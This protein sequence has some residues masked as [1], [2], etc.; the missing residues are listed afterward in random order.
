MDLVNVI[1]LAGNSVLEL[2]SFKVE[3]VAKAEQV[4][5][6]LVTAK[7]GGDDLEYYLEEGH[8]GEP[9]YTV[10]IHHSRVATTTDPRVLDILYIKDVVKEQ[11]DI[12][13]NFMTGNGG[14]LVYDSFGESATKLIT[15]ISDEGVS[16]TNYYEDVEGDTEFF[17]YSELSDALI[18]EIRVI[19]ERFLLD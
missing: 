8:Y 19:A 2:H 5:S 11:G 9:E 17:N 3:D 16:I 18:S 12:H 15:E 1:V 14:M 13:E 10:I 6:D 7:G 4:F